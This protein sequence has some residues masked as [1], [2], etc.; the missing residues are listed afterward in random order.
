MSSDLVQQAIANLISEGW[1]AEAEAVIALKKEVERLG[2]T[3]KY[4]R[5]RAEAAEARVEQ[6]CKALAPFA[7]IKADDGDTF[8]NYEDQVII[9]CEITAGDLRKARKALEG[10]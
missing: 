2:R 5:G 10:R 6:L 1:D 9:R 3:E 7:N 8:D 4:E